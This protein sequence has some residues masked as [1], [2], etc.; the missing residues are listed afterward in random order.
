MK[1][2]LVSTAELD[3]HTEW[4][5][6]DCRHDLAAPDSGL[7][8]YAQG[9][10]PGALHAH[11]DHDLSGPKTGRNGRHPLPEPAI[12]MNWLGKQGVRHGDQIVAYDD[13]GGMYAARLWWMMR[14]LGH[15]AV[16]VLDGGYAKWLAEGRPTTVA[17]P[18]Y[19]TEVYSGQ[20][21]ATITVDADTVEANLGTRAF[22]LIDARAANRYAGQDETIDPLA[23]HIPGALNRPF[24]LNLTPQGVFKQADELRDEFQSLLG[25]RSAREI[26]AQCGS[27]VTACHHLLALEIAGL[28][29]A[30][31]YPGSWSEWC[32]DPRRPMA[33]GSEP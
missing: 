18:N 31:L 21:D 10:I 32:G 19:S 1:T 6:F 8:L 26:V 22:Q 5:I 23:G 20:A 28:S 24:A 2:T 29:G 3:S 16:A 33:T 9:H 12:F 25:N 15:R 4:H 30:R 17:I 7:V 13:N 27:G 11:L 14:W